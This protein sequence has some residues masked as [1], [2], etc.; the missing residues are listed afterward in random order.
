MEL[1][2]NRVGEMV[3]FQRDMAA[4]LFF[5][6]VFLMCWAPQGK[7]HRVPLYSRE[8]RH[9]YSPV[10]PKLDKSPLNI[11]G[12]W[13]DQLYCSPPP[14]K[15][16][17]QFVCFSVSDKSYSCSQIAVCPAFNAK[18]SLRRFC[19]DTDTNEQARLRFMSRTMK[20]GCWKCTPDTWMLK[21]LICQGYSY[22]SRQHTAI[23]Y[24]LSVMNTGIFSHCS[25]F[26]VFM[27][28]W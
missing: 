24:L 13:M 11:D 8:G 16:M 26:L 20:T 28:P 1:A 22:C 14:P 3:I 12:F 9:L 6:S 19:S 4:E 23:F 7:H 10:C 27:Q 21:H 17:C 25:H 15:R 5:S 18:V 2:H